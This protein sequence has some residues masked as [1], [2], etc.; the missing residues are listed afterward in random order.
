M[1]NRIQPGSDEITEWTGPPSSVLTQKYRDYSGTADQLR[2]RPGQWARLT[3]RS[4]PSAAYQ[5][6]LAVR[7]GQPVAFKP[8]GEFEGA[9]QG[10]SVYV[11]YVG[12]G[13]ANHPE[14]A[15]FV[16]GHVESDKRTMS[17]EARER[18]QERH[19]TRTARTT[20]APDTTHLF[21]F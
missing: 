4:S 7:R 20:E 3:D 13:G 15:E 8:R 18:V 14:P 21:E 11:R 9:H 2:A 12:E 16:E 17:D 1:S 10:C 6:A 19:A 5:F